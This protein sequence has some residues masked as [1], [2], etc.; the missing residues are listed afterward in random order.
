[1]SV[2]KVDIQKILDFELY[3]LD[4]I[5]G[6]KEILYS[7]NIYT[8]GDIVKKSEAELLEYFPIEDDDTLFRDAC[9]M[10]IA[11]LLERLGLSLAQE[12]DGY[13]EDDPYKKL[14]KENEALKEENEF[15][16]KMVKYFAKEM[17]E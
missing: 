7:H 17:A 3:N 13:A 12:N 15:L 6:L 9:I 1:M 10:D 14:Q 8:I 11:N 4:F 16:K 5:S 2:E